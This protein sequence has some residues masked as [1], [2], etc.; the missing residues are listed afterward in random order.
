MIDRDLLLIK[1]IIDARQ[2]RIASNIGALIEWQ[3]DDGGL[4]LSEAQDALVSLDVPGNGDLVGTGR[5]T[6]QCDPPSPERVPAGSENEDD[7]GQHP[8]ASLVH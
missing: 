8:G 3:L 4:H 7:T 2:H 6:E 1:A 5:R